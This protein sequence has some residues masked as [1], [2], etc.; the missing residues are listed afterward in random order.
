M[1]GL[2]FERIEVGT[3]IQQVDEYEIA[4]YNEKCEHVCFYLETV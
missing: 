1:E 3:H 4:N 2:R